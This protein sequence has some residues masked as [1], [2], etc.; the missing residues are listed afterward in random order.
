VHAAR[1]EKRQDRVQFLVA[2]ER[3]AADNRQMQRLVLGD[4][5]HH[6]VDE[7]LTL[8]VAHLTERQVSTE[9]VVAVRITSGASQRAFASDLERERWCVAGEDPTPSR[10]NPVHAATIPA[11]H[12][13]TLIPMIERMPK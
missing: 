1:G 13:L 8:E 6:A 4:Q 5:P 12:R 2:H 10:D 9:V 11:V 7:F 3:F